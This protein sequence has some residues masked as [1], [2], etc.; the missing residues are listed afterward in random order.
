MTKYVL[1]IPCS[2]VIDN[3]EISILTIHQK[4]LNEDMKRTSASIREVTSS[5]SGYRRLIL[6]VTMDLKL[7]LVMMAIRMTQRQVEDNT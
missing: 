2:A 6:S 3:L 7:K 4:N 1:H 5:S